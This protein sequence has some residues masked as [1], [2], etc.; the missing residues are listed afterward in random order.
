MHTDPLFQYV[1]S[2]YFMK[3]NKYLNFK[4][5]LY[6]NAL[7]IF[8]SGFAIAG[9]PPPPGEY[10]NWDASEYIK[11][12]LN[13]CIKNYSNRKATTEKSSASET[14]IIN[15]CMINKGFILKKIDSSA[16]RNENI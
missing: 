16:E 9:G 11:K 1:K 8:F 12:E 3:Y 6:A 10:A 5:F 2:E 14:E 7:S 15:E 13:L 4:I